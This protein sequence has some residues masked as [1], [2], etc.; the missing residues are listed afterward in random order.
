MNDLS[1]QASRG[2]IASIL[3]MRVKTRPGLQSDVVIFFLAF[4]KHTCLKNHRSPS[5]VAHPCAA[6]V[7]SRSDI[8]GND[9]FLGKCV[10]GERHKIIHIIVSWDGKGNGGT[11]CA[12][13]A[14][15]G[16]PAGHEFV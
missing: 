16:A 2:M 13:G 5:W 9:D 7:A 14:G 6:V 4:Q 12:G 11:L 3:V 15:S 10:F 1:N 8:R